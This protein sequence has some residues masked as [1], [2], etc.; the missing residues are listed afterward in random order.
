MN[1]PAL[2]SDYAYFVF[3]IP[4]TWNNATNSKVCFTY[5][6]AASFTD[7]SDYYVDVK[8]YKE[9]EPPSATWNIY[10]ASPG[11]LIGSTLF[12]ELNSGTTIKFDPGDVV[13]ARIKLDGIENDQILYIYD[14]FI[15]YT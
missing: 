15:E 14:A 3:R 4:D 1:F 12:S 8:G 2:S 10:S 6:A 13:V 11:S 7:F 9:G 5:N